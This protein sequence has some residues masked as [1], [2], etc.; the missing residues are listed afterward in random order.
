MAC[1]FRSMEVPK[2]F[3]YPLKVWCVGQK[4]AIYSPNWQIRL[5]IC[6]NGQLGIF[7]VNRF[8]EA[9]GLPLR[10]DIC[11]LYHVLLSF[12]YHYHNQT[13]PK[14]TL[15]LNNMFFPV[16]PHWRQRSRGL[17]PPRPSRGQVQG[18]KGRMWGL[19]WGSHN[20]KGDHHLMVGD[21]GSTGKKIQFHSIT[22]KS[23][24]SISK[25]EKKWR[26]K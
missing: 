23:N 16:Q 13:L 2:C 11:L 7:C 19:W 9:R 21:G 10:Q 26:R 25:N 4:T 24:I 18:W 17:R 22:V 15:K 20:S 6:R 8:F 3:Q 14:A 12:K 1:W 5:D